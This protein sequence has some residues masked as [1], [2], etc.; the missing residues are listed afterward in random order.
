MTLRSE[1]NGVVG[2]PGRGKATGFAIVAI[3]LGL[4][5]SLFA[6]ELALRLFYR[7]D[8][9]EYFGA[10]AFVADSLVGLRHKPGYSGA[11]YRKNAFSVSVQIDSNG[12]RQ[13]NFAEQRQYLKRLLL[14]GD[15]FTFGLGVPEEASFASRIQPELNF[16]GVGVIN[17]GQS[18]YCVTQEALW[19]MA[20]ADTLKPTLIVVAFYP[21]ND[22]K[23]DYFRDF[24]N[25]EIR[26]GYRFRKDRRLPIAAVDFLRAHSYAWIL[27]NTHQRRSR[28]E[29]LSETFDALARDSLEVVLQPTMNAFRMLHAYCKANNIALGVMIIPQLARPTPFDRP[30][31]AFFEQEGIPYLDLND[32]KIRRSDYF[33]ND[34]HWNEKGHKKAARYLAR[35]CLKLLEDRQ[36][37]QGTN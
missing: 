16:Y 27:W 23:G 4:F 26:Y 30:M 14:L 33:L 8:E 25:V 21:G 12:F 37:Q 32:K 11:M 19:G 22:V 20:L 31:K 28:I 29:R 10:E 17:A 15:S 35:F 7:M 5:A 34:A 9:L 36:A 1:R 6:V 18:G 13:S 3:V 24:E 2:R